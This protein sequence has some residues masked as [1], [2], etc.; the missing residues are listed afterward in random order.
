M[1]RREVEGKWRKDR[2]KQVT[3]GAWESKH[4]DH[5]D[6]STSQRQRV[7]FSWTRQALPSP[8]NNQSPSIRLNTGFLIIH[9]TS[10]CPRSR[11]GLAMPWQ[12]RGPI[13][14]G[15]F[16]RVSKVSRFS[17]ARGL[18]GQERESWLFFLAQQL[19]PGFL[20]FACH[21]PAMGLSLSRLALDGRHPTVTSS[22]ASHSFKPKVASSAAGPSVGS[23][24]GLPAGLGRGCERLQV[25]IGKVNCTICQTGSPH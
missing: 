7:C 6:P 4:T 21:A 9:G 1:K 12:R 22:C 19:S 18:G 2:C 10:V 23:L 14:G 13:Q 3:K 17:T 20:S 16:A 5:R 25:V 24:C 15:S 11:P 8:S